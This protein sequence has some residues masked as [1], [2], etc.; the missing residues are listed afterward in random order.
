MFGGIS[1]VD[2]CTSLE[3]RH[4]FTVIMGSNP[5]P[6]TKYSDSPNLK[7]GCYFKNS[8]NCAKLKFK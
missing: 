4:T 6:F 2:E 8:I 3:N 1:R 7:V 5:T